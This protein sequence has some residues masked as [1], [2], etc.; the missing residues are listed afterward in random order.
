MASDLPNGWADLKA[1]KGGITAL[2]IY[3]SISGRCHLYDEYTADLAASHLEDADVVLGFN[4]IEFDQK[5]LEGFLGRPICIA[6]HIDLLLLIW[7]AISG[8]KKGNTLDE[9]GKRCLGRGKINT[10]SNAPAL[11]EKGRWAELFEYCAGDV[12]LTRDLFAYVQEHGGIVSATSDFLRLHPPF[13]L[14]GL[15]F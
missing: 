9:V 2:V 1:G 10:G 11:A 4:S 15:E 12:L 8:R 7:S 3:D 6:L 5:V 14:S 13:D